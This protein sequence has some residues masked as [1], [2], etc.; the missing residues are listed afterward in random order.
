MPCYWPLRAF[1]QERSGRVSV[2]YELPDSRPLSLPC[3]RCFGCRHERARVWSIRCMNEASLWK[4][5]SFLTLTYDDDQ[6]PMDNNLVPDHLRDFWKRLRRR[7][8][9]VELSPD[10][11]HPIRYFACG[12]YGDRTARPHYHVLVYNFVF[13]DARK[14]GQDTQISDVLSELWPYGNHSIGTVTP[15]SAAYVARYCVK[16]TH[17]SSDWVDPLTGEVTDRVPE[18]SRMSLKPAIGHWWFERYKRDIYRG[19]QIVD[20]RKVRLPRYYA[21]RLKYAYEDFEREQS[22]R[23]EV[24]LL[25]Q[26]P[27]ERSEQRLDDKEVVARAKARFFRGDPVL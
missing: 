9:G 6:L 5:N 20:G 15:R 1:R 21:E 25:D 27:N 12:E 16:K 17:R 19:Y 13:P 18:F 10:G 3:G 14:F 2:G 26:D 23:R 11:S 7:F 4:A 24:W 22:E 8:S